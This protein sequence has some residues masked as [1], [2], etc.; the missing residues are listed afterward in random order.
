MTG[1][2]SETIRHLYGSDPMDAIKSNVIDA[3]CPLLETNSSAVYKLVTLKQYHN[4][5]R[6][7]GWLGQC[8]ICNKVYYYEE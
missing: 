1:K 3:G 7:V 6:I 4:G 2:M 5:E 8:G